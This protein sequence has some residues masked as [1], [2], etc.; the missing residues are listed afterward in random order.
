[1]MTETSNTDA[2]TEVLKTEKDEKYKRQTVY[3]FSNRREF[4]DTDDQ[5]SGIYDGN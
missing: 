3:E 5:D 1:M 4:K 2:L